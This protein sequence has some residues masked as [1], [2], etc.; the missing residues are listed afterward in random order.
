MRITA[1]KAKEIFLHL[2]PSG[3]GY[4]FAKRKMVLEHYGLI[5]FDTGW[6]VDH[7][8]PRSRGGTNALG[9]LKCINIISNRNKNNKTTWKDDE[10]MYQVRKVKF[11]PKTYEVIEIKE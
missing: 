8:L 4:D 6:D 7:V 2:F 10:K 3:I 1:K 11:K 9:N 5:E